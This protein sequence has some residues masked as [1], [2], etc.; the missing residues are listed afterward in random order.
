MM[1]NKDSKVF[2]FRE[3]DIIEDHIDNLWYYFN[4]TKQCQILPIENRYFNSKLIKF[5]KLD[6]DWQPKN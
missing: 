5:F 2:F 3:M 6:V 1:K 4:Y